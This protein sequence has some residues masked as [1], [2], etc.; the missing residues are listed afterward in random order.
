MKRVYLPAAVMLIVCIVCLLPDGAPAT[1]NDA[2]LQCHETG[3]K[4]STFHVEGSVFD[5]SIHGQEGVSCVDC[6]QEAGD[7]A[8]RKNETVTPVSCEECHSQENLHGA[9]KNG[10]P[11]C[12]SCHGDHDVFS[13]SYARSHV[14]P[15][16]LK[17]TCGE[18]HPL[19]AGKGGF[20]ASLLSYRIKGHA[21]GNMAGG[22]T[23]DR[24]I[25]CHQGRGAH[26]DDELIT[27]ADCGGCHTPNTTADAVLGS[28][29]GRNSESSL[30]FGDLLYLA[31]LVIF[32]VIFLGGWTRRIQ[33][34]RSGKA[35]NRWDRHWER[36]RGWIDYALFQKKV[37]RRK[38]A[39]NS[40]ILLFI[41]FVIPFIVVIIIQFGVTASLPVG[42]VLSFLLDI[43]G[44]AFLIGIIGAFTRRGKNPQEFPT[45]EKGTVAGLVL[46][47]LI[48]ISGFMV[49]GLRLSTTGNLTWAAPVGD[50]FSF[51][52]P[53]SASGTKFLWRIHLLLVL[54]FLAI[55]PFT[56]IRH[57][58]TAPLNIYFRNLQPMGKLA[59]IRV[60]TG[61][62]FGTASARDISWKGLLDADA[63]LA[64]GRCREVCPANQ[65]QKPLSSHEGYTRPAKS[66]AGRQY[67]TWRE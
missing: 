64:C 63:C 5:S 22:Y 39:G 21:K 40:H 3:S 23:E 65:A 59:T 9:G 48:C 62:C 52:L 26:G 57:V 13:V 42:A 47:G 24:C 15:S 31:L 4:Q 33:L 25:D 34:W 14:H 1:E 44:L 41:G 53:A 54:S 29:H 38:S 35:E 45:S 8:H 55:S 12:A 43:T 67:E 28:I 16:K 46:L 27:Q 6:H 61:D 58:I 49:E 11:N 56:R 60:D 37:F 66:Y 2:C 18:C 7:E 32:L 36:I 10:A 20:P 51:V 30:V 19:Q 50:L 17:T